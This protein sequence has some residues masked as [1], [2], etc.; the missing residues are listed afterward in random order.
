MFSWWSNSGLSKIKLS[1]VIWSDT[2]RTVGYTAHASV[3]SNYKL[4]LQK[5]PALT[6]K[7]KGSG[8]TA[9][10]KCHK[11]WALP[12]LGHQYCI[13]VSF[14]KL[15]P[16]VLQMY[17]VFQGNFCQEFTRGAGSRGLCNTLKHLHGGK[18][19]SHNFRGG[20]VTFNVPKAPK[21]F[22]WDG[23]VF[24]SGTKWGTFH[25][26]LQYFAQPILN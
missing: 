21:L 12:S 4:R 7:A 11:H 25:S 19:T 6:C 24:S 8:S 13:T 20:N 14:L 26:T 1:K 5:L 3:A 15:S 16:H 2:H 22:L 10:I 17:L 23:L 18:A 9:K